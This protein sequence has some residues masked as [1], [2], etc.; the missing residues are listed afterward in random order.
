M[1]TILFIAGFYIGLITGMA[2][3]TLATP[4]SQK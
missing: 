4:E 3:I 1:T 2:A